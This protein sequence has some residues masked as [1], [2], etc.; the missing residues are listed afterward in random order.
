MFSPPKD[1]L[2]TV[3]IKFHQ[4]FQHAQNAVLYYVYDLSHFLYFGRK[5]DTQRCL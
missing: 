5:L 2:Y 1:K 3:Y 4:F